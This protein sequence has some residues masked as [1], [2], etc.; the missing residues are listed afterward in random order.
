[1]KQQKAFLA[2]K[3][4]SSVCEKRHSLQN[5]SSEVCFKTCD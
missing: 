5:N 3:N 4:K 1:M 2:S